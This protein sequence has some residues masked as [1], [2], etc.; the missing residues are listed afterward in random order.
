MTIIG[1]EV[2]ISIIKWSLPPNYYLFFTDREILANIWLF[3][4]L[5]AILYK[6]SHVWKMIFFTTALSLIIE[7]LQLTFDIG[8]FELAD[9]IANSLGGVLGIIACY[10]LEP[11]MNRARIKLRTHS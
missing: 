6:L 7:I 8:A 4:P 1:R 10:I 2:G 3:I 5:G 11:L 9:L